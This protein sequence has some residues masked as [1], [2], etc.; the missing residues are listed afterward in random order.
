MPDS[1]ESAQ[2][3]G[4]ESS[5]SPRVLPASD[6]FLSDLPEPV[7]PV[8]AV[9][10]P[11]YPGPGFGEGLLW[12]LGAMVANAGGSL[13]GFVLM[14]ILS[15]E[16]ASIRSPEELAA[17]LK[18]LGES[19]HLSG[20]TL[21]IAALCGLLASA[22][23]TVIATRVRLGSRGLRQL[24]WQAP[25]L[26]QIVAIVGLTLPLSLLCSAFFQVINEVV[27]GSG[28]AFE[29]TMKALKSAPAGMLLFMLAVLPALWEELLF[30]GLLG[31]GLV[32]RWGLLRGVLWTSL[33]FGIMHLN[34]AQ[35]IA[36]IPLGIVLH[37][38]YLTTRSLWAPMLLH[39]LNN[40]WAVYTLKSEQLQTLQDT[41]LPQQLPLPLLTVSLTTAFALL[42]LLW[43]TRTRYVLADGSDFPAKH[44]DLDTHEAILGGWMT[45]IRNRPRALVVLC[46]A[47]CLAGFFGVV[48]QLAGPGVLASK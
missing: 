10:P 2:T 20:Q 42:L 11:K 9:A 40:A 41:I 7:A 22:V 1:F 32:S 48:W 18:R 31:R 24:G 29:E 46:S 36:V 28:Q 37:F 26:I 4:P 19:G 25:S 8:L 34:P 17:E 27:P 45:V 12:L 14:V 30:R 3:P 44:E 38:I 33:L 39:F 35:A 13:F 47:V 21:Y 6:V 23:Y 16:I 5:L 43:Q 15:P